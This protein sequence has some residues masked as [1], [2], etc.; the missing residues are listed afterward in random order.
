LVNEPPPDILNH[1]SLQPGARPPIL[2]L[3]SKA[4]QHITNGFTDADAADAGLMKEVILH[5]L[6]VREEKRR[7]AL[8]RTGSTNGRSKLDETQV[9]VIRS[10]HKVWGLSVAQLARRW[11]M[12]RETVRDII[13]RRTWTHV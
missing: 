13:K 4:A 2:C 6:K 9:C 12:P 7:A 1:W 3:S 5:D 10:M 8:A 11:D